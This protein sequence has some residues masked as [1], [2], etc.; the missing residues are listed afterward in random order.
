[1]MDPRDLQIHA[2]AEFRKAVGHLDAG[3]EFLGWLNFHGAPPSDCD[4]EEAIRKLVDNF[5]EAINERI[6]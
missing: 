5:K 6:G 4:Y 3:M 2:K 1:M